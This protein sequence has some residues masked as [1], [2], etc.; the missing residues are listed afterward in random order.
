MMLRNS[1]FSTLRERIKTL[2]REGVFIAAITSVETGTDS[3]HITD[4]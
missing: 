2:V 4:V 1:F 3:L